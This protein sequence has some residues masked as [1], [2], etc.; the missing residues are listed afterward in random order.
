VIAAVKRFTDKQRN[1]DGELYAPKEGHHDADY[2]LGR[3]L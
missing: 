3:R 1:T 2:Q